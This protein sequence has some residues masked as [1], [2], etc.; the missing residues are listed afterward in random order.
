MK[1]SVISFAALV[2][3][4]SLCLDGRAAVLLVRADAGPGGDGAS[5]AT[6]FASPATAL[7]HARSGDEI[8]VAAGTYLPGGDRVATFALKQGVAV[9]GGFAG[10]E[11]G[12]DQRDPARN[13]TV[14]SGDIG[15]PGIAADNC[16][17]VVT[18][19]DG[20]V[21]DGFTVT[22]GY[23]LDAHGVGARPAR[24]SGMNGSG[25]PQGGMSSP[26]GRP[27]RVGPGAGGPPGMGAQGRP[28]GP[29]MGGAGS[30][31]TSPQAVLSG[32]NPSDGA[33][34]LNYQASPTVRNCV[35]EN[36]Q[37]FKGGAVYNMTSEGGSAMMPGARSTASKAPLF[38]NCVFRD[39]LAKGR[40]GGVANDLGTSPTFLNCAFEGNRCLEKG[41]GMY[42]DFSCSPLVINC[43][44]TGNRAVTAGAMGNDGGSGPVVYHVTF[45]RNVADDSGPAMYQGTGTSN[46]PAVIRSVIWGNDCRWED[47]AFYNWQ[48]SLPRVEYS[49]IQG[50]YS[51]EGNSDADPG[52]DGSGVSRDDV[53]YKP[54]DQRFAEARLDELVRS[55][56]TYRAE[57]EPR[58]TRAS[59]MPGPSMASTGRVIRVDARRSGGD[60]ATWAT[61]YGSLSRAI[62]DARRDGAEIWVAA[63]VYVPDGDTRSATFEL[64][65]DV[66]VYGGFKGGET[67]RDQRDYT[68]RETVLSGERGDPTTPEDNC[69]H[70]VTGANAAILDGLTITGGYAD[71]QGRDAKGAGMIN[72]SVDLGERFNEGNGFSPQVSNCLFTGNAADEG[73]AVFNYRNSSPVFT[74]CLFTRNT[75][76]NGGAVLDR[77][78]VKGL[79]QDCEFVGNSAQWRG[80][81]MYFDYGARPELD[82][83][84]F[85]KN[86]TGG[87]GGAIHSVSRASQLENTGVTL[88]DCSFRANR[89]AGDGGGVHFHDKTLAKVTFC[90]FEANAAGRDGG[91]MAVTGE[92]RILQQDDAFVSN[93]A[94]GRGNDLYM[95][96]TAGTFSGSF[97]T[98]NV[99]GADFPSGARGPGMGPG[100]GPGMGLPPRRY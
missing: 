85:E 15:Q 60:G 18:G 80:G 40:G 64:G 26:G 66:S 33:G 25:F 87:F 63:G 84:S 4:L 11:T 94:G 71:G 59:R 9:Y 20:A 49:V 97:P 73:G 34:M 3:V 19:A 54:G 92:S 44:F 62:Q 83:C 78:G 43:L 93:R 61:A 76:R 32:P 42:N 89:A 91:A 53:G 27:G 79:Y 31:H 100:I 50:G 52:L 96:E 77:V 8:W 65:R 22:G 37:A 86:E 56:D 88:K 48:N 39:N 28:G 14:L 74:N 51:G 12:R 16:H 75:A 38:V 6:A 24:A 7:T 29:G 58:P 82:G 17:H 81:A 23:S 47:V 98:Q 41:G 99:T 57:P 69:Y 10:A 46:N 90:R 36:N 5:W 30:T 1:S 2:F 67:S 45:T 21:L 70:V 55:L 72:Y 35:F 68:A 13:V 95:D